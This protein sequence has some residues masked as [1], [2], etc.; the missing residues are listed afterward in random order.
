[1]MLCMTQQTATLTPKQAAERLN[2]AGVPC[3]GETVRRWV[4]AGR[5]TGAIVLPSGRIRIPVAVVDGITQTGPVDDQQQLGVPVDQAEAA[6]DAGQ[7]AEVE[8]P[9]EQAAEKGRALNPS[10]HL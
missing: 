7:A 6:D 4:K 2:A 8:A 9:Q 1:M 10:H 5:L 3:S